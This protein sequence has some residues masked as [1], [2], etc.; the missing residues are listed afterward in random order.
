MSTEYYDR[1]KKLYSEYIS[2]SVKLHNHHMQFMNF[3]TF[4]SGM[5]ERKQLRNMIILQKEMV[6]ISKE[7]YKERMRN[8]KELKKLQKQKNSKEKNVMD[9]S[10]STSK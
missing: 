4:E 1:Y 7:V 9:L 2:F 5:H 3:P 10:T 8:E 6:K